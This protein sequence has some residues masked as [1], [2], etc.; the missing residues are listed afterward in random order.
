MS[1]RANIL[2]RIYHYHAKCA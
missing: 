2:R 1:I